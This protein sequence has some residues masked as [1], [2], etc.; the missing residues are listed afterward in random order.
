L[1]GERDRLDENKINSCTTAVCLPQ[2]SGDMRWASGNHALC[3]TA[4]NIHTNTS[5]SRHSA[6]KTILRLQTCSSTI[7][8]VVEN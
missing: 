7:K 5:T 1:S 3:Q 8:I 4:A 6:P 2:Q